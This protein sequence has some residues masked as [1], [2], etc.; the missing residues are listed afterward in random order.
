MS[1]EYISVFYQPHVQVK[2]IRH[3]GDITMDDIYNAARVIRPKSLAVD[4]SGNYHDDDDDDDDDEDDD[5]DKKL[6][7]RFV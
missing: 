7:G 4:F 1:N 5:N 3:N 2:N 6:S